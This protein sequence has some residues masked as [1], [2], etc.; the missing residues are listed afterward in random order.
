TDL[1]GGP[2]RRRVAGADAVDDRAAD[3]R[4]GPG[5]DRDLQPGGLLVGVLACARAARLAGAL[6]AAARTLQLPEC[7]RSRLAAARGRELHRARARARSVR[8]AS[9]VLRRRSDG[10][11]GQGLMADADG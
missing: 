3:C 8:A 9:T 4:P 2:P 11:G 1:R 7:V 5:R 6:H 10:G